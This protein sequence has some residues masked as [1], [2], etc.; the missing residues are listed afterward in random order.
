MTVLPFFTLVTLTCA[1]R[2]SV[3][4][5]LAPA[6]GEQ[7]S[8][9]AATWVRETAAVPLSLRVATAPGAAV[10][11]AGGDAGGAGAVTGPPP[12]VVPPPGV[13]GAP[14]VGVV[15]VMGAVDGEGEVISPTRLTAVPPVVVCIANRSV[16]V[17]DGPG[18]I[19]P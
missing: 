3:P 15:L 7:L 5:Q 19:G 9:I 17:P 12:V 6:A 2:I 18:A 8:L 4:A 10:V 13:V 16:S 14:P 11:V 1:V